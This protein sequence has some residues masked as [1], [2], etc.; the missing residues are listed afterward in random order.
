MTHGTSPAPVPGSRVRQV[1]FID[2]RH[3]WAVDEWATACPGP[4]WIFGTRDGGETWERLSELPKRYF[5]DELLG[6]EFS[7]RWHGIAWMEYG[8][9]PGASS[10]DDRGIATLKTADGGRRWTL[11]SLRPDDVG[12]DL[13]RGEVDPSQSTASDGTSWRLS[14]PLVLRR[15]PGDVAWERTGA[16]PVRLRHS[17]GRLFPPSA[18]GQTQGHGDSLLRGAGL[19]DRLHRPSGLDE[20]PGAN[21]H[22][23]L[24]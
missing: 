4:V 3:G 16:L 2:D 1:L 12:D 20:L 19:G 6:I 23:R 7:D 13:G 8:W 21:S 10:D 5:E 24:A 9:Y 22:H 14:G 18:V 11:S 15:K 17:E